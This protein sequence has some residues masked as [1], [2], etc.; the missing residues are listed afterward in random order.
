M[1]DLD[2]LDPDTESM[3]EQLAVTARAILK[4]CAISVVNGEADQDIGPFALIARVTEEMQASI[5]AE[6]KS[7]K[8]KAKPAKRSARASQLH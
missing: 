2:Q 3:L 6:T 8:P 7:L 5:R 4:R 1:C